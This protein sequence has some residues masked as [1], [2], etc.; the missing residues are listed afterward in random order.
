LSAGCTAPEQSVRPG[1]NKEYQTTPASEWVQRFESESREIFHERQKILD[2]TGV[3]ENMVV[4][5]V[6][7]GTG[8]FTEMFSQKVGMKGRVYAVDITPAF[9][10]QIRKRASEQH[11]S[12][13]TT[14]LCTERDSKLP[15]NSVDLAFVC[16][17]YH[18]FEYPHST[19]SS[20]RRALKRGGRLVVVDFDRIPGKSRQ[21][22]LDHVRVG[23]DVVRT[24]IEAAGFVFE[25]QPA[26]P[27]LTENY[28]LRFKRG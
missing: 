28:V 3:R 4:A 7:A 2:A 12:N 11:L 5:D 19:L 16:D 9:L 22:V 24:E 8:F 10:E 18:H 27:F 26:T 6:G 20:I 14:I 17:T 1:V 25:D 21:W 13:V 23:K 15:A